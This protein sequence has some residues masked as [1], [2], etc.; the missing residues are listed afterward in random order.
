MVPQLLAQP[1]IAS[2]TNPE[3]EPEIFY[4][5]CD[6]QPMANNTT[7]F[8]WIVTIKQNLEFIFANE[9]V[10]IAGDLFWYPI[11]GKPK[12]VV[13]PDVIVAVGRPK[14]D[15]LSYKQWKEDNIPPQVVFEIISPS[16]TI[17]EMDMKLLFFD[18]YGVE[19]Y[20]IYDPQLQILR[21][22]LRQDEG[23]RIMPFDQDWTSLR[24]GIHFQMGEDGLTLRRPDGV[25]F[26]T[27]EEAA[28]L[29]NQANIRA[30]EA[31]R[32]SQKL[33]EMLQALGVDPNEYP[34]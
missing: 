18:R 13:A 17:D 9:D 10:F 7:Q 15:R 19:E 33:A 22:F 28:D 3:T 24:L 1:Q 2:I 20:Y 5:D 23:L 12:I 31:E 21:V 34:K 6:G 27:F 4:P 26:Q 25:A 16:N 11:E 30:K 14:G 8:R 32:R 29:L